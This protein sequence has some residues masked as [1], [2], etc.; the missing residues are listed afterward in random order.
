TALPEYMDVFRQLPPATLKEKMFSRLNEPLLRLLWRRP[1]EP[2]AEE[3]VEWLLAG[4]ESPLRALMAEEGLPDWAH[5]VKLC[6]SPLVLSPAMRRA[7]G[8]TLDS[9]DEF[10]LKRLESWADNREAPESVRACD[11]CVRRLSVHEGL[12]ELD[13]S[14]P[15]GRRDEAVQRCRELLARYGRRL[16]HPPTIWS[17]YLPPGMH[18]TLPTVD[19]PAT[20]ADVAEGR[21]VFSLEGEARLA[22]VPRLPMAAVWLRPEDEARE[23]EVL[24]L[25]TGIV[26]TESVTGRTGHVWQAEEVLEGG[27]WKRYYGFMGRHDIAM[28]PA[29]QV[30]FPPPLEWEPEGRPPELLSR[31]R[32]LSPALDSLVGHPGAREPDG[33]TFVSRHDVGQP[34]R[35]TVW[36]HNCTGYDSA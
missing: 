31:W 2:G 5:V 16:V 21:A 28:L 12:P 35:T 34:M 18:M 26:A 25:R 8:R 19:R 36:L 17:P 14:W 33:M 10:P 23:E 20:G 6:E 22:D 15:L 27:Q 4:E 29:G 32:R 11:V 1:G 30:E 3:T 13:L 9:T 7:A 24:D